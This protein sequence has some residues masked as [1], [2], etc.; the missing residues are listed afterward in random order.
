MWAEG[1]ENVGTEKL[2]RKQSQSLAGEA[3][4]A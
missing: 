4:E 3:I 1:E 2:C